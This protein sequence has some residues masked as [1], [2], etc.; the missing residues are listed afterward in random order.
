MKALSCPQ[1]ANDINGGIQLDHMRHENLASN[2]HTYVS[3]VKQLKVS[4]ALAS[5]PSANDPV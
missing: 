2:K 1:T 3:C 4:M 5:A